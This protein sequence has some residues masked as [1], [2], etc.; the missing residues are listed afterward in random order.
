MKKQPTEWEN[1]LANDAT[2]KSLI[3]KIYKQLMPL[4][5][6]KTNNPVKNGQ[7][8][9]IDISVKK[10]GIHMISGHARQD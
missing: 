3:S 6:K 7:K 2:E 8:T 9:L 4:N 5:N 10:E 1:I